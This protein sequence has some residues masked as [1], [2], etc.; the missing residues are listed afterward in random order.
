M[1]FA[2]I[3]TQPGKLLNYA[4]CSVVR[5]RD[6]GL[7]KGKDSHNLLPSHTSK[8]EQRAIYR[9]SLPAP[10]DHC[11]QAYCVGKLMQLFELS[12]NHFSLLPGKNKIDEV[13]AV[14]I[15]TC[16]QRITELDLSKP[17]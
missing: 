15:S 4:L 6:S 17:C 8:Y 11:L 3:L 7:L 5:Q 14:S 2:E 10:I 1:T 12:S 9:S 16:L 13:G